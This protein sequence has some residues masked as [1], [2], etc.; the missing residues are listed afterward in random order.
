MWGS[1]C[2]LRTKVQVTWQT[3]DMY[4]YICTQ[5]AWCGLPHLSWCLVVPT[6][7]PSFQVRWGVG[8]QCP[9]LLLGQA[10]GPVAISADLEQSW[11][12]QWG[13]GEAMDVQVSRVNEVGYPEVS[14]SHLYI[15]D[16]AACPS[17]L[18][19]LCR[20]CSFSAAGASNCC[21]PGILRQRV[22][23]LLS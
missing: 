3:W 9:Q 16:R 5:E 1:R 15:W 11:W 8:G 17:G 14:F 13:F 23:N 21:H 4:V 10:A 20:F 22:R 6:L 18:L 2:F 7:F 12:S 19:V